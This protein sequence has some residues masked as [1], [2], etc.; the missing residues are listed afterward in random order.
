[1]PGGVTTVAFVHSGQW[2]FAEQAP[3]V[4]TETMAVSKIAVR[5][6]E[7]EVGILIGVLHKISKNPAGTPNFR[8]ADKETI[9]KAPPCDKNRVVIR[10]WV[11]EDRAAWMRKNKNI[12]NTTKSTQKKNKNP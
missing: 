12:K 3:S 1:V 6:S 10:V 11:K 7:R 5:E 4:S 9:G 8:K 2:Q